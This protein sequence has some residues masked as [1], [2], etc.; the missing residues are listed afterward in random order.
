M[1]GRRIGSIEFLTSEIAVWSS[2][3]N[4]SQRGVD[5]PMRI[6]AARFKLKSVYPQIKT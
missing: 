3:I 2:D 4:L 5:W 1:N 6:D